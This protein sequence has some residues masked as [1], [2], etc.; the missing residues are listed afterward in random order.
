MVWGILTK[1][2]SAK[3]KGLVSLLSKGFNNKQNIF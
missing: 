2:I 1:N 3:E